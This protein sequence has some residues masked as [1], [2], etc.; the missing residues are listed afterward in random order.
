MYTLREVLDFFFLK[1]VKILPP[2]MTECSNTIT[3]ESPGRGPEVALQQLFKL[4]PAF[5]F[6]G[7]F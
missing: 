2:R 1:E 6:L 3:Q 7:G 5:R 4:M